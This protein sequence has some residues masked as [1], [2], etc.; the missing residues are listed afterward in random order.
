[1]SDLED[2][3]IEGEL[4][5][6]EGRLARE[7][8]VAV[9][10]QACADF[11][12]QHGDRRL[13]AAPL[14]PLPPKEHPDGT[15]DSLTHDQPAPEEPRERLLAPRAAN[16]RWAVPLCC[17]NA[18]FRQYPIELLH[19]W[20]RAPYYAEPDTNGFRGRGGC[21]KK[22]KKKKGVAAGFVD[23]YGKGVSVPPA[24]KNVLL[25]RLP[26]MAVG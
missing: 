6:G 11:P 16:G 12:A 5:P 7:T 3:E 2:G 8:M 22:K 9:A 1:M 13:S 17:S 23:V 4:G 10:R 25:A 19:P 15:A 14:A 21:G 20:C 26:S 24:F 18:A